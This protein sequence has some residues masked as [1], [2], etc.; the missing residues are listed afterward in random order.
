[1]HSN[2]KARPR[3]T[4]CRRLSHETEDTLMDTMEKKLMSA[5]SAGHARGSVRVMWRDQWNDARLEPA[6]VPAHSLQV[7]AS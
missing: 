1:M 3:I 6:E 4:G 7:K 2:P 5:E